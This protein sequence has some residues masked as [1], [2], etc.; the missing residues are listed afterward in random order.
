MIIHFDIIY[1]KYQA[2]V[3]ERATKRDNIILKLIKIYLLVIY[4]IRFNTTER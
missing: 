3:I 1:T 2:I 4:F